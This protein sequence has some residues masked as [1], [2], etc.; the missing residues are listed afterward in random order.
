MKVSGIMSILRILIDLCVT[1]RKIKIKKKFC[2]YCLQ[3]F[4]SEK[5]LREH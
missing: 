4:S 1:K 2:R 5:V 3:Y